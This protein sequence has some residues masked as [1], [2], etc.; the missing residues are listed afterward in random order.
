M[1]RK[2]YFGLGGLG[3]LFY[4]SAEWMGWDMEPPTVAVRPEPTLRGSGSGSSSS[5]SGFWGGG[6]GGFGGGK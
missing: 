3:L 4:A 6:G 2:L 5:S 1:L